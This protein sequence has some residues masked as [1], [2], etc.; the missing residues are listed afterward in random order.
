MGPAAS[1]PP[2][3]SGIAQDSALPTLPAMFGRIRAANHSALCLSGGGM[4]SAAFAL[5]VVQGLARHGVLGKFTYLSTVSGGG[6]TGGW[7]SAWMARSGPNAVCDALGGRSDRGDRRID[8]E[9]EPVRHLR[10]HSNFLAPR[11]GLLSADTWALIA[12]LLRNLLLTWLVLLPPLGALLLV[13]RLAASMVALP[14]ESWEVLLVVLGFDRLRPMGLPAGWLVVGTA[15]AIATGCATAAIRFV[16]RSRPLPI[17][18]SHASS[19][20]TRRDA[21][22]APGQRAFLW[23]GLAPLVC[24]AVLFTAAW[25]WA[26]EWELVPARWQTPLLVLM[27]LGAAIHALGFLLARRPLHGRRAWAEPVA[28]VLTGALSGAGAYGAGR[29]LITLG[30][31]E[32][33]GLVAHEWYAMLA[34]PLLLGMLLVGSE[35]FLGLMSRWMHDGEREWSARFH[36]WVLICGLV[37]LVASALVF[38]GP[39]AV[40]YLIYVA[41]AAGLS[42]M[43]TALL[44]GSAMTPGSKG[45]DKDS[46]SGASLLGKVAGKAA[47]AALALA[48]P[49]FAASTLVLL[50][51]ADTYLLSLGCAHLPG[52]WC[53]PPVGNTPTL[54]LNVARGASPA[55]VVALGLGLALISA[56]TGWLI[57]TNKFSLRSM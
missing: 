38:G 32:L 2:G 55:L 21:G 6:Y 46:S 5:G 52:D 35:L 45:G 50:A 57:D 20:P 39:A 18:D 37:W 23:W 13:P 12:T 49:I 31:N 44:G 3:E 51:T 22:R 15:C 10:A 17:D 36:G 33:L 34:L 8:P 47:G 16:H 29:L 40:A 43:A 28:V 27:A 4:R 26:R 48:A 53:G 54:F 30:E 42:G 1:P 9:P 14:R 24:A 25:A 7:L 41:S 11:L 56:A 19:D